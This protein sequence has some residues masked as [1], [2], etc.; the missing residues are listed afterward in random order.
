M[1]EDQDERNDYELKYLASMSNP[2]SSQRIEKNP[3]EV[4]IEKDEK[5]EL[6]DPVSTSIG[7]SNEKEPDLKSPQIILRKR[8]QI[9]FT[10]EDKF[11]I[12]YV[13]MFFFV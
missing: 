9:H 5:D 13:K 3:L 10:Y 11:M 6:E 8:K 1:G 7:E 2:K 4:I 12:L